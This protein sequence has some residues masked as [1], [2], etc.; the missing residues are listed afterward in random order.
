MKL[1]EKLKKYGQ[2]NYYPFHMPGHKR[3]LTMLPKWNPYEM[4]I[5]EIDGFDNLHD[6]QE[7]LADTMKEIAN[8]RGAEDSFL[9]INGT[10]CGLL[11]G[12]S[13]CVERGSEVIVARNCHKAV[14]HG[15]FLNELKPHYIYPPIHRDHG[16]NGGISPEKIKNMLISYPNTKLVILTSPTYEGV[17]SDIK[18]IAKVVHSYGI[19]LLVDQAHGA[20]F[21]IEETF[22]KS[23]VELGADIVVE[24]V[25]KTLPAFTQTALL[26][27]QGDI[28]KKEK[29]KQYLGIFETSSPSYLMMAGIEW[30]EEFCKKE[31]LG[32]FVSYVSRLKKLRRKISEL[33]YI[34][35]MDESEMCGA[36]DGVAYDI[37]K[38]VIG[39]KNNVISGQE[40]ADIEKDI[41]KQV[42]GMEK[43]AEE[44][45]SNTEFSKQ[46]Y[47]NEMVYTP[48]EADGKE[49][50]TIVLEE[51]INGI[52]GDYVYLYPPGI[53]L[54]VP[55]ERISESMVEFIKKCR[56]EG[57]SVKG[58][59]D[60]NIKV[61]DC[62]FYSVITESVETE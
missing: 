51:A 31:K 58:V 30:C 8:F 5:T 48:Y 19:P 22:P 36:M 9:L 38:L 53:P 37:G 40:L 26:H 23:A 44:N 41:E 20:H 12:I 28:V 43:K 60:G 2:S 46:F 7:I 55:G 24:S 14:Y 6:A 18:Q 50:K 1:Y 52:V 34:F 4:D 17:V 32:A 35:L 27:L 54:L 47:E 45:V 61:I 21:G 49:K 62:N 3:N 33:T 10:T 15:I 16:I 56:R 39:V 13:A 29:I 59:C 42:L 25:H 57:L 11:A